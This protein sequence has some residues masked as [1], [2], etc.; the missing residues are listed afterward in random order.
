MKHFTLKMRIMLFTGSIVLFTLTVLTLSS[1]YNMK[2]QMGHYTASVTVTDAVAPDSNQLSPAIN[3]AVETDKMSAKD[4]SQY[5][6]ETHSVKRNDDENIVI[7]LHEAEETAKH[8][9]N[10]IGIVTMI[11]VAIVSMAIA[12]FF[13]GRVLKPI[14][15]LSKTVSGITANDL[16]LR[17]PKRDANDE[18]SSLTDSFNLMLDRLH[19]SFDRQKRFSSNAAHEL[20]TPLA[21]IK[22]GL[23]SLCIEGT[24]NIQDYQEVFG[25]I[26][27]NTERLSEI[28]DSLLTLTNE[29]KTFEKDYISLN[30][31]LTEIVRDL[32]PKY[33]NQEIIVKYEFAE[34]ECF[35]L[36]SET[37]TYRL[38]YNLIENA[39]KYN[40]QGGTVTIGISEGQNGR[41]IVRI[42]DTGI[43][44]P[45]TQLSHIWEAFYCVEPSRSKK[46]GGVGLG[47]ALVKEIAKQFEWNISVSSVEK[48]GTLFIIEL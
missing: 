26:S 33:E 45:E 25:V 36:C 41:S 48:V 17:L 12:Y 28:V 27:R 21:C 42:Q 18:I 24:E 32:K 47:L 30:A 31:M 13:M 34:T 23:Q 40:K 46:L 19:D 44:I 4:I 1:V 3:Y 7:S 5:N 39:M 29:N 15:E 8:N 16:S 14:G 9:Y 37:L 6:I 20:K 10:I 11:L 35:V 43:G 22:T 38:F 2:T